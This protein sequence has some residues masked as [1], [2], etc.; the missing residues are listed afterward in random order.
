[1]FDMNGRF[2]LIIFMTLFCELF[3]GCRYQTDNN[4]SDDCSFLAR[5]DVSR[6]LPFIVVRLDSPSFASRIDKEPG[7]DGFLRAIGYYYPICTLLDPNTRPANACALLPQRLAIRCPDPIDIILT[8]TFGTS[9]GYR[10][11]SPQSVSQY[12]HKLLGIWLL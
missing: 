5:L 1:M 8:N 6:F 12:C 10:F 2:L 7:K 3:V 11:P 4:C 9:N